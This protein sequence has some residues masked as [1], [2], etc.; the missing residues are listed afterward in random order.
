[1]EVSKLGKILA[2]LREGA[3]RADGRAARPRLGGSRPAFRWGFART[4]V[5]LRLMSEKRPCN[6]TPGGCGGGHPQRC[7]DTGGVSA[8]ESRAGTFPP[9]TTQ[10]WPRAIN[11]SL[12]IWGHAGKASAITHSK[13]PPRRSERLLSPCPSYPPGMEKMEVAHIPHSGV[14]EG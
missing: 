6:P 14:R 1:M 3:G 5:Q 10:I 2:W 8:V 12:G 4:W 9:Q 7:H 13:H 11:T